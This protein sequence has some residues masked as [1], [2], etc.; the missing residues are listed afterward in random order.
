M[1][2]II[3]IRLINI[4]SQLN[5]LLFKLFQ[6]LYMPYKMLSKEYGKLVS[7][8]LKHQLD[9]NIKLVRTYLFI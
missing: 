5:D 6:Q 2:L 8:Y 1:N 4:A 9:R 7:S 3:F